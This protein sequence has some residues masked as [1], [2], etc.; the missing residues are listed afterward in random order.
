MKLYGALI[1]II[2]YLLS[3]T[4]ILK[5]LLVKC[6]KTVRTDI[7]SHKITKCT[8]MQGTFKS[9]DIIPSPPNNPWV[10]RFCHH[11]TGTWLPKICLQPGT[12]CWTPEFCN[13]QSIGHL[14]V[15]APETPEVKILIIGFIIS[16][17]ILSYSVCPPDPKTCSISWEVDLCRWKLWVCVW[18]W[19]MGDPGRRLRSRRGETSGHILLPAL[20]VLNASFLDS[21]FFHGFQS[22]WLTSGNSV[23]FPDLSSLRIVIA[24]HCC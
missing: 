5:L 10:D 22:S 4:E 8:L 19:S 9:T 23:S 16:S 2:L 6:K 3:A 13:S 14:H 11:L 12:F 7:V 20:W 1:H 15:D 24:S 21:S 17:R 18:V